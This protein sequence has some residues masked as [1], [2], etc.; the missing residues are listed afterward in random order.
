MKRVVLSFLLCFV[1][2][3]TGVIP[4][5]AQEVSYGNRQIVNLDD[6]ET[7]LDGLNTGKRIVPKGEVASYWGFV[8]KSQSKYSNKKKI[9]KV[10]ACF[11]AGMEA[12]VTSSKTYTASFSSGC[13][14]GVK[15]NIFN[16]C[17][18]SIGKSLTNSK[19]YIGKNKSNMKDAHIIFTP[20][21]VRI[22]GIAYNK[23]TLGGVLSTKDVE[24]SYPKKADGFVDGRFSLEYHS[25]NK[26]NR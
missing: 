21:Y 4:V 7:S 12:N 10:S 14:K 20:Y 23:S 24:A 3:C 6:R 1:V 26:C 13:P 22:K 17:T 25:V 18:I 5:F 19:T 9:K 15:S 11:A 16:S 8:K 2:L